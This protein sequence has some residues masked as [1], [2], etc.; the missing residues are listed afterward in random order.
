MAGIILGFRG[1]VIIPI[2][3]TEKHPQYISIPTIL[4]PTGCGLPVN[5]MTRC[6]T[7]ISGV[8]LRLLH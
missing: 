7:G 2:L 5:P 8:P 3:E 4:A 6:E 1:R